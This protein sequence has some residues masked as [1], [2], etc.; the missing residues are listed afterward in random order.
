MVIPEIRTEILALTHQLDAITDRLWEL[1]AQL[2]RRPAV[3]RAPRSK[4]TPPAK[5]IREFAKANPDMDYADMATQLGV[6]T[7]RI[8]EA[9]VGKRT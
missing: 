3:R 4:S 7:G 1:E 5:L 9:L 2:H 8:T 6:A